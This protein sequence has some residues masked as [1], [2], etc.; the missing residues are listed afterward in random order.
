[1]KTSIVEKYRGK[2]SPKSRV[3]IL[4]LSLVGNLQLSVER[5]HLRSAPPTF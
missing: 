2:I 4:G 3:P 1:V 5:L